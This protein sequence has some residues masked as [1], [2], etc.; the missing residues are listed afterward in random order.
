MEAGVSEGYAARRGGQ[1]RPPGIYASKF[2]WGV[3]EAICQRLA[4]GESLRAIC[5]DPAMPTAKT[6]WNWTQAHPEFGVLKADVV[7]FARAARRRPAAAGR[8]PDSYTPERGDRLCEALMHGASLEAACARPGA[9]CVGTV[10]NWLRR[11]P[12]FARGYALARDL[13]G[14]LICDLGVERL[15]GLG[16]RAARRALKDLRRHAGRLQPKGAW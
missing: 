11:H 2:D 16:V 9:P 3:A 6:V 14:D 12:D 15:W 10:Y 1:G 5:A 4:A 7:A 8:A 13:Q